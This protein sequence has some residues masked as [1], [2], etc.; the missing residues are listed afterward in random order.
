MSIDRIN[1]MPRFEDITDVDNRRVIHLAKVLDQPPES[2]GRGLTPLTDGTHHFTVTV[3]PHQVFIPPVFCVQH[4]EDPTVAAE[5]Y[6]L[7]KLSVLDDG[8]VVYG[9]VIPGLQPGRHY[10]IYKPTVHE[11]TNLPEKPSLI[12][13]PY[14]R[15]SSMPIEYDD[16][17][18]AQRYSVV[19]A[20]GPSRAERPSSP[21]IPDHKRVI[22]EAH[23]KDSTK[24]HPNVPENLKG[25]YLGFVDPAHLEHLK[26]LGVTTI[27][28]L[29]PFLFD[30]RHSTKAMGRENHWG[31]GSTSHF[32]P[33][34]GY[35]TEQ[36][37]QKPEE[38]DAEFRQMVDIL[39]ANGFEVVLDVVYNH[40]SDD[41]PLLQL[42]KKG[43][44]LYDDNGNYSIDHTGVG[45]DIDGYSPEGIQYIMDSL[46]YWANDVGVDG[47]RFDLA[48]ALAKDKYGKGRI[49]EHPLFGPM[50]KD[51]KFSNK[52]LIIEPW[53]WG[54]RGTDE[55]FRDNGFDQ[56]SDETK[57]ILRKFWVS[58]DDR[59]I[60]KLS[61]ALTGLTGL[62]EDHLPI[63]LINYVTAHDGFNL[64]D[65]VS[66]LE[67]INWPNGEGNKDG[68]GD[69]M[70]NDFGVEGP[71]DNETVLARRE[72]AKRNLLT[73]VLL[74][75]GTPMV[76]SGDEL[77]HT[78]GGNNN[79][80]N[81]DNKISYLN[82]ELDDLKQ[83]HLDFTKG[84]IDLRKRCH[85]FGTGQDMGDI[86][87]S[88][89]DEKGVDWLNWDYGKKIFGMYSSGL[90]G[91][92]SA[93]SIIHY[94]NGGDSDE[95]ITLPNEGPMSGRYSI[96]LDTDTGVV[97]PENS[98][99]IHGS[100]TLKANSQVVLMRLSSE[101]PKQLLQSPIDQNKRVVVPFKTVTD[102]PGMT[103]RLK[104]H[105]PTTTLQR[106]A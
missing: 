42:N 26:K 105:Q 81:Q 6:Q 100:F 53:L 71:T 30:P 43:H 25:T 83:K 59:D 74:A 31:Y 34:T 38:I 64:E 40:T 12:L 9:G 73:S 62:R 85:L 46:D 57:K 75:W 106:A 72:R 54:D 95:Q 96:V 66:Y 22:Y 50:A 41:S 55:Q 70:S 5:G 36:S 7:S 52:L 84:L 20:E 14:G 102:L 3:D 32:A 93:M 51:E 33:H 13:D 63:G 82:W 79:N 99:P 94:V 67:K 11:E 29:P 45:N 88:P 23:V 86:P 97:N 28:L 104:N 49:N 24:L 19:T 1:R 61:A 60:D 18:Q 77:S 80:W 15:A 91:D 87:D 17:G 2:I 69:N 44:Y 35:A 8:S 65:L 27:E 78:K 76:L 68:M 92:D 89:I 101:R 47:F 103:E 48:G 16:R 10:G 56:W 58:G 39:H 21:I 4:E 90:V 98:Q 37:Q